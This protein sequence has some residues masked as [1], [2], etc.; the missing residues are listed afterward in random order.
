[1]YNMS[2]CLHKDRKCITGTVTDTHATVAGLNTRIENV[3]H[4]LYMDNF[5]TSPDLFDDLLSKTI[6]CCGTVRPNQKGMPQDFI[7]GN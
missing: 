4:K 1:M 6:N 5:F 2:K 3:G 7:K